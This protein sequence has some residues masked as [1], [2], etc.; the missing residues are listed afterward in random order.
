MRA[1]RNVANSDHDVVKI[2]PA[3]LPGLFFEPCPSLPM[4]NRGVHAPAALN[5][6]RAGPLD[7][8]ASD[9]TLAGQ[10]HLTFATPSSTFYKLGPVSSKQKDA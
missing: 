1:V 2:G 9:L 7:R 8:A 6:L 3:I 10:C 5:R 4:D